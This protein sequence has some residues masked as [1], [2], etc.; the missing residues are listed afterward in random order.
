MKTKTELYKDWE[1]N[2]N[3]S[4]KTGK[5]LYKILCTGLCLY[6]AVS[7]LSHFKFVITEF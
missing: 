5:V 3:D 1:E 7:I 2:E 6:G 4:L